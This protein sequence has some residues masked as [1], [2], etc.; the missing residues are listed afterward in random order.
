MKHEGTCQTHKIKPIVN[1]WV[2]G[3]C[4]YK[5]RDPQASTEGDHCN[6][7][8]GNHLVPSHFEP[9]WGVYWELTKTLVKGVRLGAK[10]LIDGTGLDYD[11]S[12]FFL[13]PSS[14]TLETRKWPRGLLKVRDGR[15]TKKERLPAKPERMVF[16]SL[17]IFWHKNW[18]VDR[19]NTWN[20]TLEFAWTTEVF[21]LFFLTHSVCSA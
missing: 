5:Q 12:L 10:R 19:P 3:R 13:G 7:S 14:K 9:L 17:V 21:L 2:W 16:H 1:R 4:L 8:R 20:V 15:G 6:P 18:S 11:Q